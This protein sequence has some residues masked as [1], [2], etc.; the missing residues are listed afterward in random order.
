MAV[1]CVY[2]HGALMGLRGLER[3]RNAKK[4]RAKGG[5]KRET[6]HDVSLLV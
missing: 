4:S 2:D 6:E 5:C 3:G 1:L